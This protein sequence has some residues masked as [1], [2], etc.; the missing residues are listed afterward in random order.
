MPNK[1]IHTDKTIVSYLLQKA[2]KPRH[3]AFAAEEER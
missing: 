2:Q 3:F 1:L